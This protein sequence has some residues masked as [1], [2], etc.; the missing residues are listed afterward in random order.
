MTP[1]GESLKA[2]RAAAGLSQEALAE[3]AGVSKAVIKEIETGRT[4]NPALPRLNA[5]AD[6]L[7]LK[8]DDRDAFFSAASPSLRLVR[9]SGDGERLTKLEE[10]V[11]RLE[12]L[13]EEALRRRPRR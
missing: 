4:L 11:E 7:G 13:L 12:E 2:F 3:R 6:A 8:A 5:L 10:R 9:T 1:L